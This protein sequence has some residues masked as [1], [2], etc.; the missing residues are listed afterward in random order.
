MI[1]VRKTG[2]DSLVEIFPAV[3]ED[4]RGFFTEIFNRREFEKEG[5]SIEFVQDNLSF[6]KK[7]VLRGLHLQY[8]PHAQAKLVRVITGR[9]LDTV[10]DIRKGSPTF[11]KVYQCELSSEKKNALLVPEGFAHG[12]AALE[13]SIFMYKCSSFYSPKYEGGIRWNDPDLN[14]DWKISQPLVSGKD[15]EL[16]SFAEFKSKLSGT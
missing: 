7:G 9:V 12:F 5:I 6:S 2:I 14:I 15:Q 16:P 10:V 3:F 8:P 11:G 13:D 4:D 1:E